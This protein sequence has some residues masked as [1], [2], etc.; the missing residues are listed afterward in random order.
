MRRPASH[1]LVQLFALLFAC[2]APAFAQTLP[3]LAPLE[4]ELKGGETHSYR[5]HLNA[6]QF[7]YAIVEQKDIDVVTA[8]FGPD[9]KQLTDSDSPND[10]WDSEPILWVASVAGE[11]RVDV[12][13]P[14]SKAAA[15]RYEIK[16]LALRE[17]TQTDKDHVAAQTAFDEGSK[18]RKQQTATAKRGAIEKFGSAIPMFEAAGDKYRE[19]LTLHS[20]GIACYPLNEVRK[21]LDYFNR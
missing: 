6:N 4:R 11:Y 10:R 14:N 3:A 8:V 13:S 9:G 7:L 19:A 12:R 20:I 21:A 2:V 15:G 16:I 17:A 18:L 5:I 1:F